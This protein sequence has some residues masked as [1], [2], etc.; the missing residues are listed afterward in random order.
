MVSEDEIVSRSRVLRWSKN[1]TLKRH[2][3]CPVLSAKKGCFYYS[4]SLSDTGKNKSFFLLQNK[5]TA[6]IYANLL[7]HMEIQLHLEFQILKY[8]IRFVMMY[9]HLLCPE[10]F[11][12]R[13][14]M[15]EN[16]NKVEKTTLHHFFNL[17][18]FSK[19]LLKIQCWFWFTVLVKVHSQTFTLDAWH[20][21]IPHSK[22]QR[23]N[24]QFFQLPGSFN[25]AIHS[26]IRKFPTEYILTTTS[27]LQN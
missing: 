24:V 14:I 5:S 7:Q 15:S 19:I 22:G 23:A 27:G 8:F 10:L 17:K 25:V 3:T 13:P 9:H 18:F 1:M 6:R 21:N 20:Y 4:L 11:V 16:E 2:W 26:R 12:H